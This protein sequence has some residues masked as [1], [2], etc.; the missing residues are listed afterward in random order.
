LTTGVDPKGAMRAMPSLH[1]HGMAGHASRTARKMTP[2]F[3]GRAVA[4]SDFAQ[5]GSRLRKTV[6]PRTRSVAGFQ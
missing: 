6:I 5:N 3:P 4:P 2:E 1:K